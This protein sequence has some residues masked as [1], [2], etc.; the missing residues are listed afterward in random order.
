MKKIIASINRR[1]VIISLL[2]LAVFVIVILPIV[3][4]VL[5]RKLH[6]ALIPDMMIFYSPTILNNL[7]QIYGPEGIQVYIQSK[8]WFDIIWPLVYWFS[9]TVI[10]GHL[11]NMMKQKGIALFFPTLAL[12]FDWGEN[13]LLIIFF[14]R[15][16]QSTGILAYVASVL[17]AGKW[18]SIA[19]SLVFILMY[20]GRIRK[21]RLQKEEKNHN[22]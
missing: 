20:L 9:L 17:T 11:C 3:N 7:A 16:P 18:V 22:E 4:G 1:M 8:Y 19:L 14:S 5:L 21:K 10:I 15:Y 2:L 12:L 13:T 6:T